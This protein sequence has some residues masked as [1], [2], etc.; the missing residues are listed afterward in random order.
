MVIVQRKNR[1][2]YR[3]FDERFFK[4]RVARPQQVGYRGRLD[5][6]TNQSKKKATNPFH[7]RVW[8]VLVD[9]LNAYRSPRR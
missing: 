5:V 7:S 8:T 9:L 6:R 2:V 3:C 1:L 4:G